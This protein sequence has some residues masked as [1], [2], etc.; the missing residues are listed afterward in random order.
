MIPLKLCHRLQV[1]QSISIKA[2]VAI[3]NEPILIIFLYANTIIRK[4]KKSLPTLVNLVDII[5]ERLES[6]HQITRLRISRS[7]GLHQL[8]TCKL[9]EHLTVDLKHWANLT[10]DEELRQGTESM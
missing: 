1:Y 6:S 9:V 10:G 2:E 7:L 4:F 8:T 5:H 3:C